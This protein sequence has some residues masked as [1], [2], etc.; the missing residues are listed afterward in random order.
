ML[1]SGALGGC[2]VFLDSSSKQCSVDSDCEHF[3]NHPFCRENVCVDSGL[4]PPGCF[5][6][7][8]TKQSDFLNQCT[9]SKYETF[10][11]C[12]RLNLGCP[13]GNTTLPP[14]T[15]PMTGKQGST[16]PPPAPQ[17]LCTAGASNVIWLFGSA[18]FGPLMRAAQPSLS[19]A[20]IPYRAVFQGASSCQG[21]A[22]I[23]NNVLM[24]DPPTET[25]GGW[26]F[27]FDDNGNQVNCRIGPVGT[28]GTHDVDIGISNLYSTTCGFN[29]TP[30]ATEYTGP[31]VPFVL[32]TK[33]SSTERSI[34]AEAARLVFGNGGVAPPGSGMKNASPWTDYMKYSIRNSSAGSTVL[35]ALLIGVD[36]NSFW[37]IDRVSTENLR[38]SLLGSPDSDGPIGILSIDF[39]DKNRGNLKALYLQARGQSAG[40]L[41]DATPTTIDKINV[42]DGH[43]PLWG[44]VHFVVAL[45]SGQPSPAA[46]AMVLLFN[47][48]KLDQGLVDEIIKAS[49]TPQCAMKVERKDEIGDYSVRT[50]FSCGCYFDFKTKGKTDCQ[51]CTTAEDCPGRS[52]CNYGYCEAQ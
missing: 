9:T 3:G 38:D 13:G 1:L 31:V 4:G 42:R 47:V 39:Y 49:E 5:F 23:Y 44:Y 45:Q 37:G 14:M 35:T 40:Y 41:P 28:P 29:P 25:N 46:N 8:P 36:R 22:A 30:M 12:D 20:A 10:D 19:A 48:P 33:A 52:P 11:N 43:Y 50:G 32:A 26:P 18:D 2:S 51:V 6:G 7:T 27:Y 16:V 21:V 24:K 34:S 17:N 15:P